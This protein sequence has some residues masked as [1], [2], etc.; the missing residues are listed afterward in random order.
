MNSN[1]DWTDKLPELFEGYTEAEPDG[2]WDAVRAGIEPKKKRPLGA[3]WYA[4]VLLAAA[5]VAAVALLLWPLSPS[6]EDGI[7]LVPG[8]AIVADVVPA[9]VSDLQ[10]EMPS[11]RSAGEV[12]PSGAIAS[13]GCNGRGPALPGGVSEKQAEDGDTSPA[14]SPEPDVQNTPETHI[15]VENEE[16][17]VQKAPETHI[18]VENEGGNVQKAPETHTEKPLVTEQPK[19]TTVRNKPRIKIQA[20]ISGSGQMSPKT[21]QTAVNSGNP[22]V[23]IAT[24]AWSG[25]S[26]DFGMVSRNK[27]STTETTHSQSARIALSLKCNIGERWGVESGVSLSTLNTS[28]RTVSGNSTKKTDRQ[29]EYMGIPLYVNY[30]ALQWNRFSI[31]LTAGPM[32]EYATSV[33]QEYASYMNGKRVSSSNDDTLQKDRIWSLNVGAGLQ[34]NVTEHSA[35]FVQP[36]FSYHFVGGNHIETYYTAHPASFNLAIGYRLTLF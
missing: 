35:L 4:G 26:F 5:A 6:A 16:G 34:W 17:N 19:K 10:E 24:K 25:G 3:L 8:D 9:P 14:A 36:G 32:Y 31:Y 21:M 27:P 22:S 18:N 23:A 11:A 33:H 7:S 29:V 2:L 20:G 15:N 12:S 28:I 13:R 30:N 1:K